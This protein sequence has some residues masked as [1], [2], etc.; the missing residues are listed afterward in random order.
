MELKWVILSTGYGWISK[1]QDTSPDLWCLRSVSPC[2]GAPYV[3]V[4]RI[5]NE[6]TEV[7]CMQSLVHIRNE[8]LHGTKSTLT[9]S[10]EGEEKGSWAVRQTRR[11]LTLDHEDLH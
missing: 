3:Y 8:R 6:I 9:G 5:N 7:H 10:S 11:L 4:Q 1:L 2:V